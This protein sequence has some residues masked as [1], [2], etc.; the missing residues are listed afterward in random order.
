MVKN[1]VDIE[2]QIKKVKPSQE[3][4]A[5]KFL[6]DSLKDI[7]DIDIADTKK[8]VFEI[9]KSYESVIKGFDIEACKLDINDILNSEPPFLNWIIKGIIPCGIVG[10]I[11]GAGGV[12]K[13]YFTLSLALNLATGRL[14]FK[15]DENEYQEASE[16]V[17]NKPQKVLCIYAE[18]N[19]IQIHHR[20]RNIDKLEGLI[21]REVLK[22]NLQIISLDSMQTALLEYKSK[23]SEPV[24]TSLYY[25]LENT[26]KEYKPNLIILDP[27]SRFMT[28]EENDN[29][30]ATRFIQCLES[31]RK[32]GGE[33]TSLL[34]THHTRKVS[35][36]DEGEK[37]DFIRGAS[38]IKDGVRWALF[39]TENKEDVNDKFIE[40]AIV[41]TNYTSRDAFS[42]KLKQDPNDKGALIYDNGYR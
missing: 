1:K 19:K 15:I 3:I 20:I 12:G 31:L 42:V 2:K 18:D 35:K 13:S 36:R 8:Q 4:Q 14:P 26:I 11:A 28:G 38:A 41:K 27:A 9:L 40:T 21:N 34:F 7:D 10:L 23:G 24:A 30:N 17:K 6:I 22:E 39:L 37:Y 25:T 5:L 16:S 32:V 33:D 29:H